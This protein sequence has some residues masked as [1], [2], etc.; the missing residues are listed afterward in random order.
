MSLFKAN[1][2]QVP[3]VDIPVKAGLYTLIVKDMSVKDKKDKQGNLDGTQQFQVITEVDSG[4]NGEDVGLEKGKKLFD[5]IPVTELTKI[6]RVALS[7]GFKPEE[8]SHGIDTAQMP[9]RRVR[10]LVTNSPSKDGKVYANIRDY[11]LPN[12]PLPAVK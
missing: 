9:N 6:K 10:A 11:L 2:D 7:S 3:D 1:F 4:P 12:D 5:F 8:I